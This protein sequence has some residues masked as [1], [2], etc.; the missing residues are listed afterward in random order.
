[1]LEIPLNSLAALL[2]TPVLLLVFTGFWPHFIRR[3]KERRWLE[4]ETWLIV[5]IMIFDVRSLSRLT[6]WDFYKEFTRESFNHISVQLV[7]GGFNLLS[8]IGGLF[9]LTTLY[10]SIPKEDRKGW[11]IFTAPFYPKK[12]RSL[13]RRG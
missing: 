11:N 8:L 6:Y 4:P 2:A 9:A 7:N 13:F 3:L 10:L 1:M 12:L 5:S